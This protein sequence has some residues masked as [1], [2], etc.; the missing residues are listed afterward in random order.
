MHPSR[1]DAA[2]LAACLALAALAAGCGRSALQAAEAAM[3]AKDLPRAEAALDAL[4]KDKPGLK[5]AHMDRFVLYRFA[6]MQGDPASQTACRHQAEDEYA[7]LVQAYQLT[8]NFGDME[9]SLTARPD[10]AADYASAHQALY[11]Q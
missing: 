4:V 3:A 9:A 10:A 11:A 6:S 5:A 7:W 8:E 1:H 2:L